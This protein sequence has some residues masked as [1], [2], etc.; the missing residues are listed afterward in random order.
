M[1]DNIPEKAEVEDSRIDRL[2][3]KY[4]T[5]WL[6]S[7]LFGTS[8]GLGYAFIEYRPREKWG[9]LGFL[10]LLLLLL[11]SFATLIA[12]FRLFTYL[13]KFLIPTFFGL[14]EK[15]MEKGGRFAASLLKS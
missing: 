15:A 13:S 10:L 2:L 14:E 5:V 1:V 7:I 6:W 8:I 12:L 11:G 3:A 9:V 4:V